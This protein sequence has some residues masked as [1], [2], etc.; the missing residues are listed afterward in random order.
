MS[1]VATFALAGTESFLTARATCGLA[2]AVDLF[3]PVQ[4]EQVLP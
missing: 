2:V 4:A 3:D 1:A